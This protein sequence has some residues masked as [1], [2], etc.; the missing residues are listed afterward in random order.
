[1]GCPGWWHHPLAQL[2]QGCRNSCKKS[3][4]RIFGA[5]VPRG[6]NGTSMA[7]AGTHGAGCAAG[8]PCH[9]LAA[10]PGPG[11]HLSPAY[12]SA[13]GNCQQPGALQ[14]GCSLGTAWAQLRP[15]LLLCYLS[16]SP[17]SA[18]PTSTWAQGFPTF[19]HQGC[20]SPWVYAVP[21]THMWPWGHRSCSLNSCCAR[22]SQI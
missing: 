9:L 18:I 8:G 19:Q 10:E 11:C 16:V 12:G 6:R 17:K 3:C 2:C 20:R 21:I 4:F 7:Q 5:F 14:L 1:M 22:N 13:P 15:G